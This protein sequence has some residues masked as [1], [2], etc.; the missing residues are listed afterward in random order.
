MR[1]KIMTADARRKGDAEE[2]QGFREREGDSI[3]ESSIG[4]KE[5]GER[6]RTRETEG[7][8]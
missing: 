6:E 1:K 5:G 4:R 8:K 3:W 7:D 2:R